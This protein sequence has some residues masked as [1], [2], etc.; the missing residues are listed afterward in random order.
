MSCSGTF[1]GVTHDLSRAVSS[2]VVSFKVKES[3][4]DNGE[5]LLAHAAD[6]GFLGPGA[7][8][9]VRGVYGWRARELWGNFGKGGNGPRIARQYFDKPRLHHH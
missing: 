8:A 4:L 5:M 6:S 1:L 9:K 2:C 3:T 7:A